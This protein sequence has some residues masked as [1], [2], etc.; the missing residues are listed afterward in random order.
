MCKHVAAT[1]YGVGARLDEDPMLFFSLRNADV[2]E[3]VHRT[4]AYTSQH[5]LEKSTRVSERVLA[6]TDM[7]ALFDIEMD[8]APTGAVIATIKIKNVAK[9]EQLALILIMSLSLIFLVG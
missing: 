3:L 8:T 2:Q 4:V 6:D 7:S 1:L 5:L 9:I